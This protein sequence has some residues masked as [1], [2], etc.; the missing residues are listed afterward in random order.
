MVT[1]S[2]K[3]FIEDKKI[4]LSKT[5]KIAVD[6]ISSFLQSKNKNAFILKGFAGTGKTFLIAEIKQYLDH[7]NYNAMVL[8]PTGRSAKV[9]VDKLGARPT[10]NKEGETV[11][12]A[13]TIHRAIYKS[14]DTVKDE[15]SGYN[16]RV[17]KVRE[18]IEKNETVYFIDESSMVSDSL[19]FKDVEFGS[20]KLLQDLANYTNIE[21][22]NERKIIF[23]GDS[24]QLSPIDMNFSPALSKDYLQ[25]EYNLSSD[26][27]E[28]TDI[29]RQDLN[30]GIL[31]NATKLRDC[32][33]KKI[34]HDLEFDINNF[35]DITE[36]SEDPIEKYISIYDSDDMDKSLFITHSTKITNYYNKNIRSKIFHLNDNLEELV[37]QERLICIANNYKHEIFNGEFIKVKK[38]INAPIERTISLAPSAEDRKIFEQKL[39]KK[40]FKRVPIVLKW[41]EAEIEY[42]DSEGKKATKEVMLNI[43]LLNTDDRSMTPLQS[44]ALMVDNVIRNKIPDY[45]DEFFTS[46]VVKYGYAVVG[47]KAQ[48]GEWDNVMIDFATHD[49]LNKNSEDFFRWCYTVITRA[50]ENNFFINIPKSVNER[51]KEKHAHLDKLLS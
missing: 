37:N 26:E 43:T 25:S 36:V 11:Y 16:K 48:G 49:T 18:N 21:N 27:Y 20:G 34:Y 38:L 5:Q 47:H 6:K 35:D 51:E 1:T 24:A 30:S 15:V 23:V 45:D 39:G 50:K 40:D 28:L 2:L 29:F 17:F 41:Q 32:I 8:T 7:I 33:S 4:N 10:K 31:H 12:S 13:M 3:H 9:A 44:Q 14:I 46:L 42:Y 19:N 22:I